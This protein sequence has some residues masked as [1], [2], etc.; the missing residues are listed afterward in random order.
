[1][2][3]ITIAHSSVTNKRQISIPAKVRRKLGSG[4]GSTLEW[5]RKAKKMSCVEPSRSASDHIHPALFPRERAMAAVYTDVH[6]GSQP[7]VSGKSHLQ[8]TRVPQL[9]AT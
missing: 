1:M 2:Q 7:G 9:R 4:P 5:G 3:A 8:A 6:F